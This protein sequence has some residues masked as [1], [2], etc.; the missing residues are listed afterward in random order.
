MIFKQKKIIIVDKNNSAMAVMSNVFDP[1]CDVYAAPS[2]VIMF[3]LLDEIQPDMILLDAETQEPDSFEAAKMLRERPEYNDIAIA[4]I[5]LKNRAADIREKL[6]SAT[7]DYI[8][9]PFY[10]PRLLKRSVKRFMRVG[11]KNDLRKLN[12]SMRNLPEHN[13]G[14]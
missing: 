3:E 7:E 13:S 1:S 12:D 6:D 9:K 8:Y 14:A 10:A 5:T 2:A 4:F 11:N